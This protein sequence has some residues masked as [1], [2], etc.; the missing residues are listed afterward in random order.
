MAAKK[1]GMTV[2]RMEFDEDVALEVAQQAAE[3]AAK[4]GAETLFREAQ[5][6]VPMDTGALS[7]S[8]RV[9]GEG[10]EWAVSYGEAYG[11]VLR[12][13]PE[14]NYQGGRS[15]RWLDEAIEGSASSVGSDMAEA[16][17]ASWPGG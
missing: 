5:Q 14:W 6:H 2:D 8:G 16:A 7:G 10:T 9:V 15:G 12:G 11:N 3:A 17:Q 1:T 4:A 13:H